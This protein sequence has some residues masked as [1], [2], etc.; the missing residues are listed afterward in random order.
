VRPAW[1]KRACIVRED[2]NDTLQ[3]IT[4]HA[5]W[6]HASKLEDDTFDV[7]GFE[8]MPGSRVEDIVS[9]ER[10][11]AGVWCGFCN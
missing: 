8:P 1:T 3:H 7:P 9:H 2:G 6:Q 5:C 4:F 10:D 11:S